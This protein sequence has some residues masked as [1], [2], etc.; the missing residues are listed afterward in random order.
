MTRLSK[1]EIDKMFIADIMPSIRKQEQDLKDRS[2][3]TQD[4]NLFIDY[5]SKEGKITEAQ[6][7]RYCIPARLIL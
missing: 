4:Y 2:L 6:A 1:K 3:R 5:L 7:N